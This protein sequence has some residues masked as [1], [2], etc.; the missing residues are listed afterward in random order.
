MATHSIPYPVAPLAAAIAALGLSLPGPARAELPVAQCDQDSCI[1]PVNDQLYFEVSGDSVIQ[2]DG[3]LDLVGDVVLHT[4]TQSFTLTEAELVLEEKPEDSLIPF[5]L[6]GTARPQMQELPVLEDAPY[7]YTPLAVV[8][9][10]DRAKLKTLM[11]DDGLTLPLSEI[12]K[13]PEGDPNDLVEPAYFFFHFETGLSAEVSLDAWLQPDEADEDSDSLSFAVPVEQG[14]TL[15][16]DPGEP[17]LLLAQDNDISMLDKLGPEHQ[18]AA[19]SAWAQND[20]DSTAAASE[21]DSNSESLVPD[22]GQFAYSTLGGIPFEPR[23][24]WGL[25]PDVGPFKGHLLIDSE[26]PLFDILEVSGTLVTRIEK[27]GGQFGANG[28]LK[29]DFTMIPGLEFEFPVLDG[30]V[31]LWASPDAVE[32]YFSGVQ[33][34]DYSFLPDFIPLKP[35]ED[36]LVAGYVNLYELES[37]QI[38][39]DGTY[40]L[41]L[42]NL[43]SMTGL[44]LEDMTIAQAH[45]SLSKEGISVDGR[46]DVDIHPGI[47]LETGADMELSIPFENA[48]A[49]SLKLTGQMQIA[50]VGFQNASLRLDRT[51][52][53]ATGAFNTPLSQVLMAGSITQDG[54]HLTGVVP[55][56][57][58]SAELFAPASEAKAAI[59]AARK[60]RDERKRVV[61]HW[62]AVVE[63]ERVPLQTAVRDARSELEAAQRDLSQIDN[64]IAAEERKIAVWEGQI[65]A[66]TA[67]Y[68]SLGLGDQI[69]ES[70]AYGAYIAARG[71]W[72]AAANLEIGALKVS[73][74]AARVALEAAEQALEWAEQQIP[75]FPIDA[76]PRVAAHIPAWAAA[77]ASY[78]AAREAYRALIAELPAW[79]TRGSALGM[80]KFELDSEGFRGSFN[81]FFGPTMA[82]RVELE[83]TP[84]ACI[85]FPNFGAACTPF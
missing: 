28:D 79:A 37:S 56:E 41:D 76:D 23:N 53:N 66:K 64:S 57:F 30:T 52:L 68:E 31:G 26:I 4:S 74:R 20:Q 22:L 78:S 62:R 48:D 16:L 51:G 10:V 55:I 80:L 35:T 84:R 81:N 14:F 59:A 11:E 1:V 75:S 46:T 38:M 83:P 45:L 9:L 85:D 39:A 47:E 8:G 3:R 32:L 25:P 5:H 15:V 70:F 61:D 43:R 42:S 12:P 18:A 19:A 49:T 77:S 54:P 27:H 60:V 72:I 82:A 2:H 6:Y 29:L 33:A 36:T 34:R 73:K 63:A 7:T 24:T 21:V 58:S 44:P 13:D 67:W 71:T 17:Y 50:G 69:K 40:L 65:S